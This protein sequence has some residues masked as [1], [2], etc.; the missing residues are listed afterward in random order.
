MAIISST[1]KFMKLSFFDRKIS[2]NI[3]CLINLWE[4]SEKLINANENFWLY[5]YRAGWKAGVLTMN[6]LI[7]L[8]RTIKLINVNVYK[9]W[10]YTLTKW[11]KTDL[12]LSKRQLKKELFW[13]YCIFLM[14]FCLLG[15][16]SNCLIIARH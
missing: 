7:V 14:Q 4:L 12:N 13:M 15:H 11:A 8:R 16:W 10:I 5:W 9:S 2:K 6:I 1:E 3:I